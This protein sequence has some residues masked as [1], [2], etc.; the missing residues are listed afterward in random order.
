MDFSFHLKQ[1]QQLLEKQD[2]QSFMKALD[3]FK[4]ANEMTEEGHVGKPKILYQLAIGNYLIG[5]I[6]QAYKI[7]CKAKRSI[8]VAI[9]NSII[10]MD[11]MRQMLGENDIDTI[12]NHIADKFPQAALYTDEEDDDFDENRLDFG[13]VNQLYETSEKEEIRPQFTLDD[14]TNE[15][16]DATFFGLSRTNDEL[17]YF[18]K[19]AGDVLSH[20]E[21]YFSSHIGDQSL[22]NRRL[23]DKITNGEP[24]DVVDE[25]R[26]I[27]IDRLKLSEFLNEYKIQAKGKEPFTSFVDYFSTE[28]LKDFT[29]DKNLT[30]DDLGNSNHI[31]EKFHQLFGQK[32]QTRV[33]ELK[34]DYTSIFQSTT[35]AIAFD[36]IKRNVFSNT[37]ATVEESQ[38][39]KM[40]LEEMFNLRRQC[41]QNRD[42]KSLLVIAKYRFIKGSAATNESNLPEMCYYYG[43]LH[44]GKELEELLAEKS[45]YLFMLSESCKELA[46]T[47]FNIGQKFPYLNEEE[48]AYLEKKYCDSK[49]FELFDLIMFDSDLLP[50]KIRRFDKSSLDIKNENFS[51]DFL[52]KVFG[53]FSDNEEL[54]DGYSELYVYSRINNKIIRKKYEHVGLGE[55]CIV[56]P[57]LSNQFYNLIKEKFGEECA[58][59]CIAAL[60]VNEDAENFKNSDFYLLN[61]ESI[62]EVANKYFNNSKKVEDVKAEVALFWLTKINSIKFKLV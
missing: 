50:R 6:E 25:D 28:V 5:N 57:I 32:Y 4:K 16:L 42:I 27:L 62:E 2:A 59:F 46:Q 34:T 7:A 53:H 55:F 9:E 24:A 22:S 26:Y 48:V 37:Q 35:R 41:A 14:L 13:L 11:N 31:Q 61:V 56:Q 19:L 40:P 39:E 36:W 45:F 44:R 33:L 10:S 17:V 49:T 51:R 29:Y 60:A 23:V 21:G 47:L 20:V 12:L 43:R 3:H 52:L 8:D 54:E 1:G 58:D 18:D 38:L 30:V 15:L